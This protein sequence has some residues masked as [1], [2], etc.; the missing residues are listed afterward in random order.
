MV[1]EH[2]A[3]RLAGVEAKA[4]ASVS[5]SDFRAL[6]RLKDATQGRFA[7]GVLL[8]DGETS[9]SFGDRLFAVP[10]RALWETT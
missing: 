9:A 1:L 5:S 6:S 7:A 10:I 8:Y 2:G 3:R 4:S